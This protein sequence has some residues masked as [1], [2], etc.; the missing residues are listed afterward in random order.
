MKFG[1]YIWCALISKCVVSTVNTIFFRVS[2][3]ANYEQTN[4]L[5][6]NNKS[7]DQ[8]LHLHILISTIIVLKQSFLYSQI[9]EINYGQSLTVVVIIIG[10]DKEIY[11]RK[12]IIISYPLI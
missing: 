7:T 9:Q 1:I 6:E 10:T 5:Y 2:S 8:P 4:K 11:L 3:S 12:I